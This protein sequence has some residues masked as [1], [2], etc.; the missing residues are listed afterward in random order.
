MGGHRPRPRLDETTGAPTVTREPRPGPEGEPSGSSVPDEVWER[1]LRD[2]EGAIR[3]NAPRELSARARVAAR[4]IREEK[5]RARARAERVSGPPGPSDPDERRASAAAAAIRAAGPVDEEGERR[6][7]RRRRT[8]TVIGC[9]VILAMMVVALSPGRTWSLLTGKGMDADAGP[10]PAPT[11]TLGPETGPPAGPPGAVPRQEATQRRPFA[12][13]PVE[14]W[15]QGADAIVPP[16]AAAYAA[17]GKGR[18]AAQFLLVKE[19]LTR[20]GL[21]PA[22]LAGGGDP[23]AALALVDSR[24]RDA[25]GGDLRA[26]LRAGLA[27]PTAFQDPDAVFSRFGPEV[28]L[29]S[30]VVKVRGRMTVALG[31]SLGGARILADYTFVYAVRKAADTGPSPEITRTVV[32]RTMTVEVPA[33]GYGAGPAGTLLVSSVD[34]RVANA[35]CGVHDGFL[36][37]YFEGG[38]TAPGG[39]TATLAPTGA[40]VDPYDRSTPLVPVA[41]M[42]P[43]CGRDAR[44]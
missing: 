44:I 28:R 39:P 41:G 34:S 26:A 4:R 42:N 29:A 25:A 37:P 32:R 17:V 24:S 36:H 20:T 10:L 33:P 23:Q 8:R 40:A 5:Q 38:D 14:A 9:L 35:A 2:T 31:T 1:F 21:D 27:H 6:R 15:G 18:M 19:F 16:Q 3:A 12:G 13:S 11:A 30:P 43:A 22:V 7:L